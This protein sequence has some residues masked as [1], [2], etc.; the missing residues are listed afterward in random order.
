[1]DH[2]YIHVQIT[3]LIKQSLGRIYYTKAGL[4]Y[5]FLQFRRDKLFFCFCHPF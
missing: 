4:Q 3:L 2:M 5:L 1:M